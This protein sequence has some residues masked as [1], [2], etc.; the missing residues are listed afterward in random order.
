VTIKSGYRIDH[1][2]GH[3]IGH[4]ISHRFGHRFGHYTSATNKI[5]TDTFGH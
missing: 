3:I 1:R 2:I 5:A 4:R